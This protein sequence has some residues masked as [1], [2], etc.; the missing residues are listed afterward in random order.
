MLNMQQSI[1]EKSNNQQE[2]RKKG[3]EN[4]EKCYFKTGM[5]IAVYISIKRQN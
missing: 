1:V 3:R 2:E 4:A 5:E